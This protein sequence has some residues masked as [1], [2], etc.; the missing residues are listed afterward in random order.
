MFVRLCVFLLAIH[1]RFQHR[2]QVTLLGSGSLPA[3]IEKEIEE[4]ARQLCIQH[5][6][7]TPDEAH[8]R[9]RKVEI[10]GGETSLFVDKT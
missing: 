8:R 7:S 2:L 5:S 10:A 3:G 6:F 4:Q 1:Q 9:V